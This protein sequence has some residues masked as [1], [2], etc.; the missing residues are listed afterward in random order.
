MSLPKIR[1][2]V[3]A[4]SMI[5]GLGTALMSQSFAS[6]WYQSGDPNQKEVELNHSGSDH[7]KDINGP[8]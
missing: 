1:N 6:D 8:E 2:L 5:V 7:D 3:I 4:I